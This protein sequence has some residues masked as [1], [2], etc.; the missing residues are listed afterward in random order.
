M[1]RD[2]FGDGLAI[3]RHE[4]PRAGL[5]V[6]PI[7]PGNTVDLGHGAPI[8]V[9]LGDTLEFRREGQLVAR[10]RVEEIGP[11]AVAL[12]IGILPNL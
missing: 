6:M 2:T 5:I 12:G 4:P 3:Q 8:A 10:L 7:P 11:D 9:T 1:A